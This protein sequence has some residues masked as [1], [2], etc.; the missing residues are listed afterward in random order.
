[1]SDNTPCGPGWDQDKLLISA[2]SKANPRLGYYALRL[3]DVD[4]GSAEELPVAEE[5]ELGRT[6]ES[7][8]RQV[9]ERAAGRSRRTSSV[10]CAEARDILRDEP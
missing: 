8:G 7:I 10:N 4:A 2:I 9:W 6:V 3:V 1:M 5:A